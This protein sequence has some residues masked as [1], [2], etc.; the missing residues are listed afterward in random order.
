MLT[1]GACFTA[2]V[3]LSAGLSHLLPEA[4]RAWNEYNVIIGVTTPYPMPEA[5][6]A[7]VLLILVWVSS[8]SHPLMMF[9]G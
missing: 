9:S 6:A 7:A 5:V 4:I 3:I 1:L 8:P 2:G